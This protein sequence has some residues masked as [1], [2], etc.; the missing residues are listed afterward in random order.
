M[1]I[2]I[3]KKNLRQ[4]IADVFTDAV[5]YFKLRAEAA[6]ESHEK[7]F[8]TMAVKEFIT[9]RDMLDLLI[10]QDGETFL[11]PEA[12]DTVTQSL[13]NFQAALDG[14]E[15]PLLWWRVTDVFIQTQAA[16]CLS[17]DED[18]LCPKETLH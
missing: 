10:D 7:L 4:S 18:D 2:T 8:A 11:V 5:T 12:A 3:P 15:F 16:P 9:G 17:E 13:Q 1:Q 14:K 6:D